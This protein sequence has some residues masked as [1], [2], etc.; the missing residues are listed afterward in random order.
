M[1]TGIIEEVAT[2]LESAQTATNR[3]L[4]I[5]AN[6]ASELRADQSVAHNGVCLTV[7]EVRAGSYGVTV[8]AESLAKSSLGSLVAGSRV[9]LERCLRIDARLDGHF[10]QGHVDTTGQVLA[11]ED[12][13]GSRDI[14][15][16]LPSDAAALVVPRGSITVDGISLTVAE[17]VDSPLQ[18]KVSIIPYTL[19]HTNIGERGPG[20]RLNLE[21]DVLGKYVQRLMEVRG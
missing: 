7:E 12:R 15:V 10:V 21:F 6:C 20:D 14:W 17:L 8:I 13:D 4:W 1:F 3:Q 18:F 16:S 19:L 9:N 5:R 11:I 2:V